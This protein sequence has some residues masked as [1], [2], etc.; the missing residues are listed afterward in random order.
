[1]AAFKAARGERVCAEP[2]DTIRALLIYGA[3]SGLVRERA[4]AAVKFAVQDLSDAFRL[5]QLDTRDITN[6]PARIGDELA[7]LSFGGG[8][9]AVWLKDAGDNIADSILAGLEIDFG[10]TLFV[11]ECAN[12][13]PRSALRKVFEKEPDLAAVPCY[14]DDDNSLREYVSDFLS[15]ENAA[16]DRD[17]LVWLLSRLSTDRMQVRS[18]LE[19][20]ILYAT[21][22]A[23]LEPQ[24]VT[25]ITFE[26]VTACS[27]DAGQLSLDNLADA[28]ASGDLADIDRFLQLAFEQGIQPIG[29]IRCV[30]RRFAQLH[31]VVGLAQDGGSIEQLIA[32]LRPPIFF[33]YRRA[34]QRQTMLWPMLRIAQAL[35]I[36]NEAEIACKTTGMPSAEICAR[37]LIRIGGAARAGK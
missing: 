3:N 23:D 16:I 14:E 29:A 13:S 26:M 2:P 31:F 18:E 11:I 25:N 6:D 15:A 12:L 34:F 36:L 20:L 5:C 7:A 1:M 37:A 32:G 17:A 8:R 30:N 24:A 33:K 28:V 4:K 22:S 21:A 19:K 27:A 35:D 10:D 9:R